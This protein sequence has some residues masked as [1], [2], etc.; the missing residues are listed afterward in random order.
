MDRCVCLMRRVER[1]NQAEANVDNQILRVLH[2]EQRVATVEGKKKRKRATR[3]ILRPKVLF[4]EN[5]GDP[6]E[7]RRIERGCKRECGESISDIG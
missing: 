6:R 3:E 7:G 2:T 4:D 5:R 1:T